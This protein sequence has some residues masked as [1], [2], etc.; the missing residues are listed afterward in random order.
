MSL[1]RFVLIPLAVLA[2]LVL[3][4]VLYLAFGDLGRHKG[5]IEALVT[6]LAGRPFAIDG[7]LEL[8][9]LPQISVLAERVRLANAPGG[10]AP[11]MIEIGRFATQVGLWSLVSGP[12]DIRS[13]ELSDVAVV[14]EKD[15]EGKGNWV[16]R[17]EADAEGKD[18]DSHGL[19]ADRVPAVVLHAKLDN[20]R[21][22]FREAG[23]PDRVALL[24]TFT[25][26]PAA[27]GLLAIAGKGRLDAY[28]A[29][30]SGEV[31]PLRA[32]LAG[33]D[34]RLAIK[35]ALGNLR[36]DAR[37]VLGRLA[38][39]DGADLAL[40]I[41]N[42]DLGTMLKKLHLPV[43]ATGAFGFDA[44]LTD[45]GEFTRLEATARFGDI[46]A[47]AD[48]TLRILGL[49][50]A[51][52]RFDAVAADAARLAAVFGVAGV[53]AG[54]AKVRGR[55]LPSRTEIK[56]P[57]I[58]VQ[59][60]GASA[61]A[62]G[63]ISASGA[64]GVALRFK[65]TAESLAKL[66]PGLPPIPLS[67]NG[68]FAGSRAR[69][70]VKD[71]KAR[72]DE[73]EVTGRATLT[74]GA[75]RRFE[76]DVAAPVLD[77]TK[78]LPAQTTTTTAKPDVKRKSKTAPKRFIFGEKPLPLRELRAQDATLHLAVGKLKVAAAELKDLDATV[79]VASGQLAI[80]GRARGGVEGTAS[81]SITLAPKADGVADFDL[82]LA[83]SGFRAGMGAGA[84][85]APGETP[86]TGVQAS[87][88]AR[89]ASARQIVSSA[90]GQLL[91]TTG[92]GKVRSGYAA[93]IGGDLIDELAAKLNPFSARDPYTQ[94]DCVVTKADIV[95]GQLTANPMVMQSAKVTVVA[96]GKVNLHT[97]ELTLSF[98]TLPR[99][100]VAVPA[101]TFTSTFIAVAGT[102]ANP[103]LAVSAKGAAAAVATGGITVV[104]RGLWDRVRGGQDICGQ[105]LAA[106]GA[107]SK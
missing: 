41:E 1:R 50:G 31:G 106:V 83:A 63:T 2:A 10:S 107:T 80:E 73:S 8:K 93:G 96:H 51:D 15:A 57:E 71:V 66:R 90:N 29:A 101:G 86:A 13:L 23:K 17:G 43:F 44:R 94:L 88:R 58:S 77:L 81:G 28:P 45:A 68:N 54:A 12:V 78:F 49:T 56:L 5:R 4:I 35:A 89:G 70:E 55:I 59:F 6:E 40:T 14:L 32:L 26:A 53:P 39:L 46:S 19:D 84:G 85:I 34:I 3:A 20:L 62:D 79:K 21:V 60:A 102:L 72:I 98:N 67:M 74:R 16:F 103:H 22:T 105:A 76:A 33:R 27:D 97:E 65:L 100:G 24:E 25:L 64:P 95:D 99:K 61:T 48:G 92:P 30:L 37:G 36:L 7:A 42:P 75:K 52:L 104:A 91:L 9:L 69:F 47:R 82:R 87:L 38:P 18:A 11:Q